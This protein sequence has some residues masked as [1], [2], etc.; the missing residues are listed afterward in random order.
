MVLILK[1]GATEKEM[2]SIRKKLHKKSAKGGVDLTKHSGI[3]NLKE[4]PLAI[5]QKLRDEWR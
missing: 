1:K 3:L 5:Q 4:D 2:Q